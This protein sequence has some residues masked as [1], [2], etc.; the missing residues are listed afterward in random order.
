VGGTVFGPVVGVTLSLAAVALANTGV[1]ATIMA[2]SPILVI[3][4][5]RLVHGHPVTIR[6]V[7]GA[8][9]AI[10]GVALLTLPS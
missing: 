7:L 6:A 10:A 3:A 5:V 2:T 8:A 4:L 9:V 1:A